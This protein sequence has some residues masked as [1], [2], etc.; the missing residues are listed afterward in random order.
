MLESYRRQDILYWITIFLWGDSWANARHE[1]GKEYGLCTM[2][3]V[4]IIRSR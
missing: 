4:T 3:K 2:S 1:Q